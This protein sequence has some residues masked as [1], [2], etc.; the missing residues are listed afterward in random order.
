MNTNT[1]PDAASASSTHNNLCFD[2]DPAVAALNALAD[3]ERS[4]QLPYAQFLYAEWISNPALEREPD[5]PSEKLLIRFVKAEVTVLGSG[6]VLMASGMLLFSR[7][8]AS[9]SALGYVVLPG[10]LMAAGIGLSIVPSTILA[11]QGAGPAQAGLGRCQNLQ[12]CRRRL[13]CRDPGQS[14]RLAYS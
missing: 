12:F 5:A 6:L 1:H 8:G 3:D 11:T 4:Y 7:I 10:V 2:I 13:P 9:G 14:A